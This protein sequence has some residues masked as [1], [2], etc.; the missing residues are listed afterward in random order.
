MNYTRFCLF[1]FRVALFWHLKPTTFAYL[2]I[3]ILV[4]Y[5]RKLLKSV[6][7][8]PEVRKLDLSVLR[9]N[10]A[11][12]L[13]IFKVWRVGVGRFWWNFLIMRIVQLS[14]HTESFTV[15]TDRELFLRFF[16]PNLVKNFWKAS[17]FE[18]IFM[19]FFFLLLLILFVF[20]HNL[21]KLNFSDSFFFSPRVCL[22]IQNS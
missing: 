15:V 5:D 10:P 18:I 7:C 22:H 2:S 11:K 14:I 16:L 3:R 19:N 4:I 8:E 1:I 9:R 21:F 20:D 6:K 17:V 12:A 13:G